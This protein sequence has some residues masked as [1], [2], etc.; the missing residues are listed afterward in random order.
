MTTFF[1]LLLALLG[2]NGYGGADAKSNPRSTT[3]VTQCRPIDA[4]G[5]GQIDYYICR[6]KPT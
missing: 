2:L 3:Q 4:A 1:A 5:D 6:E